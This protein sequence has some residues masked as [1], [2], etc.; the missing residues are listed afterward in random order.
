MHH[1][2]LMEMCQSF[3]NATTDVGDILLDEHDLGHPQHL[4]QRASVAVLH[5]QIQL[6]ARHQA[7]T[8]TIAKYVGHGQRKLELG[9]T[10]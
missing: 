7:T 1:A 3:E 9:D 10:S 5:H 2:V 6:P 4:G 8:H